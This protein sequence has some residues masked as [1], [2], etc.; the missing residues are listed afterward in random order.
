[1]GNV[2]HT[3]QHACKQVIGKNIPADG[4]II[5]DRSIA[6]NETVL[7]NEMTLVIGRLPLPAEYHSV[8][9][10]SVPRS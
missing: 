1:M 6:C 8:L 2:R 3:N 10:V 4:G 5:N 7:A 9:L